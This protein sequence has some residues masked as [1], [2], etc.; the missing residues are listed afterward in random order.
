[1][2]PDEQ[3]VSAIVPIYNAE[4][5]LNQ[6]LKSI[7]SQ[8]HKNLEIICL[9]DGSTD[10]SLSIMQAHAAQDSRMRV[11]DKPNQGYGATCNRGIEEASGQWIA[12]VEP[13][14][15][16]EPGMYAG[17]LAFATTAWSSLGAK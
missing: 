8:T 3:L 16:I 14:D 7:S 11:I 13:D 15:W 10:E 6:C 1:M 17:M 5:F 2:S 12:V 4:P 9:N